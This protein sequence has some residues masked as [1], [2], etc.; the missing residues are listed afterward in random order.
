MK[1]SEILHTLD[2]V[3]MY[4]EF[5]VLSY[6]FATTSLQSK[7]RVAASIYVFKSFSAVVNYN[8]VI[9]CEISVGCIAL[10][11]LMIEFVFVVILPIIS[12]DFVES[13][14]VMLF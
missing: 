12:V 7:F 13:V 5:T 10:I 4:C 2:E 9:R 1:Q 6:A 11:L 3:V 14:D 8:C